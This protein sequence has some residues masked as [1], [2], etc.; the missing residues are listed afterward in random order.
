MFPRAITPRTCWS[1]VA[2]RRRPIIYTVALAATLVLSSCGSNPSSGSGGTS[3]IRLTFAQACAC[4]S[5]GPLYVGLDAGIFAKYGLDVTVQTLTPAATVSAVLSGNI[6]FGSDGAALAAGIIKSPKAKVIFARGVTPFYI[7][8]NPGKPL[9]FESLRGATIAATTPGSA[10]DVVVRAA[11][12]QHG[13][14]PDKDVKITYINDSAADLAAVQHGTI[15]G[16]VLTFPQSS[17]AQVSGS[18]LL[19]VTNYGPESIQAVNSQWANA[20]PE[21]LKNFVAAYAEATR[22]A[23]ENEAVTTKA[24]SAHGEL[25]DPAQ[26]QEA[27]KVYR[28]SWAVLP[29]SDDTAKAVT[30]TLTPPT[31][32][33]PSTWVD[34]SVIQTLGPAGQA[35]PVSS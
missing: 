28:T 11:L 3:K 8:G 7:A 35:Q 10:S 18:T 23:N 2:R 13:L 19:D 21:A 33:A 1:G 4:A 20:N 16:A 14:Q 6:D 22:L 31:G 15:Q 5:Y 26:S 9:S 12:Q 34:N 27:W 25:P 30:D 32:A 24:L 17:Q 29:L